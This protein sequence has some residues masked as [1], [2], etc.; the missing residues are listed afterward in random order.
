MRKE[1][2]K[3]SDPMERM[4]TYMAVAFVMMMWMCILIKGV[5]FDA[6]IV[7]EKEFTVFDSF[8]TSYGTVVLTYGQGKLSFNTQHHLEED[9]TYIIIYHTNPRD[10]VNRGLRILSIMKQPK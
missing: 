4:I 9:A 6:S 8:N 7:H 10:R 5:Y 3:D 1:K 2:V